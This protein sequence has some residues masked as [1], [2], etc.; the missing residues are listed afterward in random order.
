MIEVCHPGV[1]ASD[2][3][4]IQKR[5]RL[6]ALLPVCFWFYPLNPFHVDFN[7]SLMQRNEPVNTCYPITT[8]EHTATLSS[9]RMNYPWYSTLQEA[10]DLCTSTGAPPTVHRHV[11]EGP[12]Y[13][14]PTRVCDEQHV[15]QNPRKDTTR[16]D[17]RET[18][19]PRRGGKIEE[20]R[21]HSGNGQKQVG[22]AL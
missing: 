22:L 5:R 3:G 11:R 1:V 20:G 7:R 9:R 17:C 10:I 21:P 18:S 19:S 12:R 2:A 13:Y 15:P 8:T 4:T 14:T 6:L 16:C